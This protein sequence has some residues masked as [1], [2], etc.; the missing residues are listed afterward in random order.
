MAIII[1]LTGGIGS[2]KSTVSALFKDLG[3]DV[4][5]ADKVARLVVEKGSPALTEIAN[6]FGDGIV[7]DGCLNRLRLR[8]L[9]FTHPAEK[10]WLNELLHPLIRTEIL[11]Q[12]GNAS[13][14]Y[15]L[16]EAPLLIENK[17]TAYCDYVL[18]IDIEEAEQVSRSSKRDGSSVEIIEGIMKSQ[19]SRNER[20]EVADFIINNSDS[21]IL[22]L[23]EVVA[24]FDL[25]FKRISALT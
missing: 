19:V 4:V 24:S 5:D 1:G 22:N 13:S 3:V 18:V 2:G 16:L 12:L 8:E 21:S 7:S 11:A 17:L 15:V 10:L 9:I 20:L 14:D 6:H 25:K 23:T